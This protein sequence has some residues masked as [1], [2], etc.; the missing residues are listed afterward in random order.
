MDIRVLSAESLGTRGLS[1]LVRTRERVILI[2]P[3]M[4]LGYWREGFLPHPVQVAAGEDARERI[5][6]AVKFAGDIVVSH[7]HGDHVPL[8]NANPFQMPLQRFASSLGEKVRWWMNSV[9]P[10][11][12]KAG[13][14]FRNIRDA[15]DCEDGLCWGRTDGSMSFSRPVPH[16]FAETFM[17][18]VMMT[19]IEDGN[20]VFVHASDI[21]LLSDGA[22]NQILE[23]APSILLVSGPPLYRDLSSGDVAEARGRARMLAENIGVCIFDHHLLRSLEGEKWLDSLAAES[24]GEVISAAEFMGRPRRLLEARRAELYE[25]FPV[26]E[27]W[28]EKYARGEVDT[29]EYR[30]LDIRNRS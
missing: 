2:D 27:G 4:A 23:W 3:A 18:R 26:P 16:G 14:R 12:G 25:R 20:E 17:G 24:P 7:F 21:Q 9:P 28:H 13:I 22:V 29:S 6:E 15:V 10:D 11:A 8:E 30:D 1:C 19:R 5:L